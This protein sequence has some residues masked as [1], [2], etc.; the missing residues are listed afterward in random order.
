MGHYYRNASRCLVH[1]DDLE[2]TDILRKASARF[3][4]TL[5]A[6]PPGTD[7]MTHIMIA[8]SHP[9]AY[10][11]AVFLINALMET[12][13]G[14]RVWTT[15]EALL[16]PVLDFI[17]PGAPEVISSRLI[18]NALY[19]KS[20][21]SALW[22]INSQGGLGALSRVPTPPGFTL[23]SYHPLG[24]TINDGRSNVTQVILMRR[25]SEFYVS[26][27]LDIVHS[28]DCTIPADRVYGILGLL[29]Y[30]DSIRVDYSVDLH[31][32]MKQLFVAAISHGD[33]SILYFNGQSHGMIP[34]IHNSRISMQP[35]FTLPVG[36]LGDSITEMMVEH[37]GEVVEWTV[38]RNNISNATEENKFS[39]TLKAV[40]SVI[41]LM[42]EGK[43]TEGEAERVLGLSMPRDRGE[44]R[45]LNDTSRCVDSSSEHKAMRGM[46]VHH[47]ECR[48]LL[49]RVVSHGRVDKWMDISSDEDITGAHVVCMGITSWEDRVGMVVRITAKGPVVRRVGATGMVEKDEYETRTI[50]VPDE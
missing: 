14:Q 4:E 42:R 48:I 28:R 23:H 16:N 1:L 6:A 22:A 5:E 47:G 49:A 44:A 15:Q 19:L 38:L 7:A 24:H 46:Y 35:R 31:G 30:G 27:L 43:I 34:D 40:Y 21:S 29:P 17:V 36:R 9:S 39:L 8:M 32:A 26:A 50:L 37:V 33:T 3:K 18:E 10:I 41:R 12:S 11:S 2:A 20:V 45:E 13:W 25:K